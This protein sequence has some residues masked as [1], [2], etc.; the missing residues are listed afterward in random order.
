MGSLFAICPG[1][2]MCL[3][4]M[5]TY[6]L[7]NK[8]VDSIVN[9]GVTS[10][11]VAKNRNLLVSARG[12]CDYMMQL[13]TDMT[14]PK[15]TLEKLLDLSKK[16]KNS[17][18]TGLAFVGN[19]PHV[20]ALFDFDNDKMVAHPIKDI[21][22]KPFEVDIAGSFGLLVPD[23]ILRNL[24]DN[25]FTRIGNLEED[26]SFGYSVRSAGYSFWVDPS[27]RFGHLRPGK[28]DWNGENVTFEET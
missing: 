15:N 7:Q 10:A 9:G 1:F 12:D 13:D 11:N 24:E 2:H 21:P 8:I 5:V 17:V 20:P 18:V 22:D 4:N 19:P 6:S 23:H 16:H 3:L 27:I 26:L 14:F 25:P 28:I